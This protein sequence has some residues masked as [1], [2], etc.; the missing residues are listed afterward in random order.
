MRVIDSSIIIRPKANKIKLI[1]VGMVMIIS[2][3]SFIA[4]ESINSR[5]NQQTQI[6]RANQVLAKHYN[7]KNAD[8]ST[9]IKL[10][11]YFDDDFLNLYNSVAFPNTQVI[12]RAPIITGNK[13][14][15]ER[16]ITIAK[17]RGYAISSIPL[18]PI[19]NITNN[20]ISSNRLLQPLA[21]EAWQKIKQSAEEDGIPLKLEY[22][23]R[24]IE[25][26]RDLFLVKL[27]ATGITDS[28]IA[29]GQADSQVVE[30]LNNV[31]VPGFSRHH[32]GY[33]GDFGCANGVQSFKTTTCYKWLTVDNYRNAKQFGW[34]PSHPNE[35]TKSSTVPEPW[36]FVWVGAQ[37][38]I[39]N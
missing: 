18:V 1:I 19:D 11:N 7:N 38:L 12:S 34:I 23:F 26:Q 39:E 28:Q 30:V 24:S 4:K 25:S 32:T 13:V 16:I 15:D 10:K 8:N 22:G 35:V 6:D 17:S 5:F 9:P 29:Q 37:T 36:E 31:E 14:A 21:L 33:A 20:D 3:V 27:Y 2:L